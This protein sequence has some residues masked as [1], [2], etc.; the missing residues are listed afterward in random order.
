MTMNCAT[1]HTASSQFERERGSASPA[2]GLA[3]AGA[4]VVADVALTARLPSAIGA[5][6]GW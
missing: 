6:H 3:A 1:Q 4:G 2:L 5:W